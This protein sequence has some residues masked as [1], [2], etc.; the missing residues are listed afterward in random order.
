M[1]A[2]TEDTMA[3][4]RLRLNPRLLLSLTTATEATALV[5]TVDTAAM[6]MEASTGDTT[7]SVRLRLS[8]KLLLSPTLATV[9]TVLVDTAATAME[10]STGDTTASVR[11]RLSQKL[12]LSPTLAMVGTVLVGTAATA[13]EDS[14]GDTTVSVRLRPN[15]TS[16]MEV[17][18]DTVLVAMEDTVVTVTAMASKMFPRICDHLPLNHLAFFHSCI[19]TNK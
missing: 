11:L 9:D 8:P 13:M 17:L 14:T 18:E 19:L 15:P 2:S 10:D 16:D 12:L 7:A 5:D 6:D 1:E 3:S 4:V